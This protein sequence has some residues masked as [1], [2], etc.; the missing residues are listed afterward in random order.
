M[1]LNPEIDENFLSNQAWK[2]VGFQSEKPQRDFRGGG[3]MSLHNLIF[4]SRF[5]EYSVDNIKAFGANNDSFLFACVIISTLFWLKHFFHLE[6]G[7]LTLLKGVHAT[8][9]TR[10]GL[11]FFLSFR[12]AEASNNVY[13]GLES[14]AKSART[15]AN[16]D[17]PAEPANESSFAAQER[18]SRRI[19]EELFANRSK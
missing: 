7:E 13:D 6:G 12:S 16:R 17:S 14:K 8:K 2:S 1:V 11:K 15:G 18:A 3:L 5:H 9:T 10:K 4:F 19:C